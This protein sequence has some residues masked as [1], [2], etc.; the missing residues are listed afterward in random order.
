M[1]KFSLVWL[2]NDFSDTKQN[3]IQCNNNNNNKP[4]RIILI[5][6]TFISNSRKPSEAY[7]VE[8]NYIKIENINPKTLSG[9]L[10]F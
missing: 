2:G 1:K 8:E 7:L 5:Q 6:K 9:S 10:T 3:H 4:V